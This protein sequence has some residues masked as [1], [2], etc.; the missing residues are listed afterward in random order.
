[1]YIV[2]NLEFLHT[3]TT[4]QQLKCVTVSQYCLSYGGD[5]PN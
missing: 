3:Y 5:T 4:S 2:N 1:M